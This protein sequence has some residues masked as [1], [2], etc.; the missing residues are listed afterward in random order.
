MATYMM[1]QYKKAQAALLLQQLLRQL[2]RKLLQLRRHQPELA[3]SKL[4]PVQP[5]RLL[6]LTLT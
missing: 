6:R 2:L 3:L 1:L 5:E 4:K